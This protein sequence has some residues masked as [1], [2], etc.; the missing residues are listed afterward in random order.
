MQQLQEQVRESRANLDLNNPTAREVIATLARRKVAVDPTLVVFCNYILL[1]DQPEIYEHPDNAYLPERLRSYYTARR[2]RKNLQPET[3][4]LRTREFMKYQELTGLLY[5]AGVPLLAGTD[6]PEPYCPPGFSLLQELELLVKSD[7]PPAAALQAATLNNAR[8]LGQEEQL[9]RIEAGKLADLV[10]L[11]ANP[12]DD[13]RNTR[14]IEF[15][16]RGGQVLDPE[17]A[18]ASGAG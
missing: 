11:S 1:M 6:T 18:P 4:K 10:V 13:I 2:L 12:V 3:Q 15:V 14:K 8:A 5:H 16:I 7:L 9:G 17:G